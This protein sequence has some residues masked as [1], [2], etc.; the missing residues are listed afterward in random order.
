MKIEAGFFRSEAWVLIFFFFSRGEVVGSASSSNSNSSPKLSTS[1]NSSEDSASS[2]SVLG[3][4]VGSFFFFL[5]LLYCKEGLELVVLGVSDSFSVIFLASTTTVGVSSLTSGTSSLLNRC[6]NRVFN[7]TIGLVFYSVIFGDGSGIWIGSDC[8]SETNF[9]ISTSVAYILRPKSTKIVI[10]FGANSY[11][12]IFTSLSK[13]RALFT[14]SPR[15]P[16]KSKIRFRPS[17]YYTCNWRISSSFFANAS[18]KSTTFAT[19]V[20]L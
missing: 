5:V 13:R 6:G 14:T 1:S 15:F 3:S 10:I 11:P 2:S 7:S 17:F 9:W 12:S 20:T 18:S 4:R 16:M 8:G 19:N